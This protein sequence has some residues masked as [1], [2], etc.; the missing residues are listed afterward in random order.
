MLPG[1]GSE[2][3]YRVTLTGCG[4]VDA[5]ELKRKFSM[6]PNL[7]LRDNTEEPLDIWGS[8]GE[9]TLEGVYFRL[10]KEQLK[11]DPET[12]KLAAEISRK[13]LRGREVKL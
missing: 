1:A 12:V 5:A 3:F 9:D 11:E 13:L 7:E 2:D 10:L 8:A 4:Q 6:F